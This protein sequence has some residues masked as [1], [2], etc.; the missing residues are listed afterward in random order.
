MERRGEITE[1]F[2][3]QFLDRRDYSKRHR[4]VEWRHRWFRLHRSENDRELLRIRKNAIDLKRKKIERQRITATHMAAY[5]PAPASTGTPWFSIGPRNVNGRVKSIAVDPTNENIVYAGAASGGVWKSQD[6]G[7]S[8]RP[9]W[10][11]QESLAIGSIAIAPSNHN[12]IYVG[13]GE[14]TPGYGPSYPGAGIYVSNDAGAT[15]TQRAAVISRRIARVLIS[16]NDPLRVYV[17]GESGFERSTDGGLIWTTVKAG[18]ISDAV[19]DPNNANTFYINV[20][21]DGIYKSTD[22]GD[23][24]AKLNNGP[25]GADADWIRLAIG[26]N[27]SHGSDFILAK[28][29]GTIYKTTDGGTTWTTLAGS[30]GASG[31]D[32]W[33]NLIA[34]APDDEDIIIAG[35]ASQIQRTTN[36]GTSWTN[37]TNLHADH[38]RAVFAPTNTNVVYECNDGGVY[39]SDDKG[40]TWKKASHGLVI[41]QFYDVGSWS[42]IST[43]LGGGT[44]D[45]GTNM[46]VGGL[47]WL[48]IF[49]WDGGY[50]VVNPNDPRTIYAEHQ[51]TDIHK[52]TDG[53]NTWVSKTGG[54]TGS[55]PWTGIIT[56]DPNN[57][58]TLFVGTTK[59]FRT[60]DGCATAWIQSS[61]DFGDY[62]SSIAIA[63]SNSNRIYAG[64]GDTIWRTGQGKIFRSDDGGTT[65]P[66][67]EKTGTLPSARPLMDIA[68]DHTDENRVVVCYG[69][70]NVAGATGHVFISTNGG[71][72]WTDI[73]GNLPD[74]SVNG[75]AFDPTAPNTIYVGT[76]AG[77]YRTTNLGA[78]WEAFDNGIP[79]V[80]ITDLHVDVVNNLLFVST[81]GRGMYKLSIAPGGSEPAVDLFLRDSL[82]DTG[83]RFPS[84]SNFPNP[85]D[86][87]DQV[88]FWESPEIK[89]DVAPFYSPDLVFDGV[90][91]DEDLTH[92]DP[93]RGEVNRFYLQVHN[94]GW[95]ETTNVR[96][97]A[98][99]AD[100]S[101]GL[102]PLPNALLPP[103]FNLTSTADWKPI[104]PALTIPLLEPNRPVIVS[105]DWV[106][107]TS[108]ATHSCLLA[109]VSSDDDPITTTET[110][111]GQ[112]I[113][114]EKRV[115]LK[116]LHVIDSLGPVPA[117][118]L[119]TVD[120]NNIRNVEDIIDIVIDPIDF[121]EGT[122]GLLT[123]KLEFHGDKKEA[124]RGVQIYTLRKGED[125]GNWYVKPRSKEDV[126]RSNLIE[127]LDLS[128]LYEFDS[129]KISEICGI[130]VGPRQ[131]IH[132]V[133]TCKGSRKVPYGHT[134]KFAVMQRQGGKIVGGCTYEIRLRRA[135]ALL[136][137]SRIR[138]VLEKVRIL[139]DHDPWIKGR[140][141]FHFTSCVS[142]NNNPCRRHWCR[143]PQKGHIKISDWPRL[144]EKQLDVCI[145]DGYVAETDNMS[146]SLLP[147]EEDW[148]DP[149][150]ELSLYRRHFNGPPETW[151]GRFD[152]D[153]EPPGSEAE[154][155]SDWMLWY[156]IES[157]KI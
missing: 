109:V 146:I 34:V 26:T 105:W 55:N 154:K 106:V 2:V 127:K 119:V 85:N 125:I 99:F 17:A 70:I 1:G 157:I 96:V 63:P 98:F 113:R 103:D 102:P 116:N 29:S 57:P 135:A 131:K 44:Q 52:S 145:F 30:H 155:L 140:G 138:V 65:S 144:N 111:I 149:D 58:D 77:V 101:P 94:R 31:F 152:P 43:V 89:V 78:N 40:A 114:S 24:W 86:L 148:L 136:P 97:R 47:T 18:Q 88:Y 16:Q 100:A 126:D 13:T 74:I 156:R 80:I 129:T 9:L 7:Q 142:F 25:T 68:V 139:N 35:G 117:Q 41:T 75:V 153:D 72:T 45:Q 134:Q 23:S 79:N 21:F 128:Q 82:L 19:I 112:L 4:R 60:T 141:E 150:D 71:N 54:L 83:E 137:V 53:G 15:W 56:M 132:A 95:Q 48:N 27:G 32:E 130:Q 124:L 64:T 61:Q 8:W 10:N 143:V 49:G 33:C 84:P 66:W 20:R 123:E 93:I 38:H 108:S 67:A 39:R 81:M 11:E 28:R 62:L 87:S 73:S 14:W 51:N 37:L 3:Q 42:T 120:F 59:V 50:F 5:G 69:G 107:P 118:T 76:D 151:V 91:F 115:C 36:G 90:E 147:I 92:E 46:T 121:T 110:N 133:I 122:I 12:V 104:G 6:G 22:G